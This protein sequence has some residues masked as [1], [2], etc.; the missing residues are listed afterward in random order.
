MMVAAARTI[1]HVVVVDAAGD[2]VLVDGKSGALP[3]VRVPPVVS[4]DVRELSRA[5]QQHLGL[6]VYALRCLRNEIDRRTGKPRHQVHLL[7]ATRPLAAASP[8]WRAV[9]C[10]QVKPFRI[11]PLGDIFDPMQAMRLR[12]GE[13]PWW[14]P[15]FAQAALDWLKQRARTVGSGRVLAIEHLRCWEFSWLM[16]VATE[17]DVWFL[18]CS[19][20]PLDIEADVIERLAVIAPQRVPRLTARYRAGSG[21]LM[22]AYS[23]PLLSAGNEPDAWVTAAAQYARLQVDAIAARKDLVARGVPLRALPDLHAAVAE[24]LGDQTSDIRRRAGLRDNDL[25]T[26][27]DMRPRFR[28]MIEELDRLDIP[29]S[30]DH[31]DLWAPNVIMG[32]NGPRFLDWSDASITHPFF[33]MLPLL[34]ADDISVPLRRDP[35]LRTRMRD[36]YLPPWQQL[37]GKSSLARAWKI[38]QPLA[39]LHYAAHYMQTILP[40]VDTDTRTYGTLGWFL[41][42]AL[43]HG[44]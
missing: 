25:R 15:G 17:R 23:E 29:L 4:G 6:P 5:V 27:R 39:A 34:S 38:A 14:Q 3:A 26:L 30:I 20:P 41:R 18:K 28:A 31:G 33:S 22:A 44:R 12:A 35:N 7:E 16:R 11:M 24:L 10:A 1:A 21:F 43:R 36:A 42:L 19:P 9:E 37:L 8:P 40:L 13:R 2:R 32:R